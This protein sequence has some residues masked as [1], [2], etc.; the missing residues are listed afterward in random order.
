MTPRSQQEASAKRIALA[1]RKTRAYDL[2]L[3]GRSF[4]QIA[5]ALAG[6]EGVS[7]RYGARSAYLDVTS[8]LRKLNE[9][10]QEQ[11]AE[12]RQLELARLDALHE[13]FWPSAIA[14]DH[15]SGQ[16]VLA[17]MA[18]RARLCGLE[19]PQ[20]VDITARVREVAEAAGF[21]PDEAVAEAQRIVAAMRRRRP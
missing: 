20:M 16:T 11:A 2:R 9:T 1:E 18:Q 15:R 4:R 3:G 10:L 5:A 17:I 6:A 8:E 19:A 7:P 13:A 21:D 14:G 12:L